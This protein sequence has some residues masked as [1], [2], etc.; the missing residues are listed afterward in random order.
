MDDS[1]AAW[2]LHHVA[3]AVSCWQITFDST[4]AVAD[5]VGVVA[6]LEVPF[7]TNPLL[8]RAGVLWS[9][10]GAMPW[11]VGGKRSHCCWPEP[12]QSQAERSLSYCPRQGGA[13]LL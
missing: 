2:T 4:R 9:S 13:G 7:A 10:C 6:S 5:A 3:G 12:A 8:S 1:S 11:S